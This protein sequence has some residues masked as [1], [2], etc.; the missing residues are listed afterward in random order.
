M[1]EL[2]NKANMAVKLKLRFWLALGMKKKVK[3]YIRYN[4]LRKNY[5][6]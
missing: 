5:L 3:M 2:K 6:D 4:G 1:I